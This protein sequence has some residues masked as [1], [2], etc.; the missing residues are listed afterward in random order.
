MGIEVGARAK[1]A[2]KIRRSRSNQPGHGTRHVP[3]VG[4][5]GVRG[6]RGEVVA[7]GVEA[8]EHSVHSEAGAVLRDREA[9][10]LNEDAREVVGRRPTRRAR[11]GIRSLT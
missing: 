11:S 10:D 3:V 5:S 7:P 4:E 6:N 1:Q 9:G 8:V 2:P